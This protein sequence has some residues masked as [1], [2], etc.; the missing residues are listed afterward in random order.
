MTPVEL[1]QLLA[2]RVRQ[3]RLAQELTQ[4]GLAQRA[5][6]SLGSLKRFER[7]GQISLLALL[8]IAVALSATADFDRLFPE[9]PLRSL[10]EVEHRKQR[11]RGRR[12]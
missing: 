1:A 11:Q 3:R 12:S 7:T 6:V 5:G 10:A 9:A 8:R 4:H 2:Q